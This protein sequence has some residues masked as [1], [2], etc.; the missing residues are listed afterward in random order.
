MQH[1]HNFIDG[2][3]ASSRSGQTLDVFEPATGH[4]YARVADSTTED[5]NAA[6]D[7]AAR[8]F[9]AWNALGPSGRSQ[10]LL[11]L[12]DLIDK[13]LE[14]LA[15]AESIDTGKPLSL[16]RS[17]DIPRSAAN[18]RFFAT[19]VLHAGGAGEFHEFDGGG[20]PAAQGGGGS[21]HALNYTLRAPRGSGVAGLISPWNLPL[22]LLT[23]KIAPALATG[24][25]AVC[26]PS[27]V[28]PMTATML[29]DLAVRAGIP[30]GVL[31]IVQGRG[32][33]VGG[34]IVQ[35]PN[36]P[37]ISFTGSTAVGRWIGREAGERL[38]RV[39]LELGGKNPFIVF[40]DV[41]PD[42]AVTAAVRGGYTNQGQVC[43]CGSRLLVHDRVY[44]KFVEM[45]VE[46]VRAFKVGDP[47]ESST[48]Q[49]ALVSREH[50][51]KVESRVELAKRLGARVLCGGSRV[52]AS[53]LPERCRGGCF[54]QPTVLE[55]LDPMCEVEQE[56]IFGPVVSLQRFKS[57]DEALA[58]AN[59]TKYGLAATLYTND[60]TRAHALAARVQAGIVW[61]NCW[62]V[63]DLRT[64]FGG[65]GQSGVGRE[66]GL[67]AIKFFTEAKNVCVRV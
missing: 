5:V 12:A 42:E 55:G 11:R 1:L 46:R 39:S 41:N 10:L 58:L 49:G 4:V 27:E 47:L 48:Q 53:A 56:E 57:D 30:A 32:G 29:G 66:G 20:M 50:L 23:W 38:K 15:R 25:T 9:P 64:P 6:V 17:I 61:V 65:M 19:A 36:V 44:A 35:H 45:F 34:T 8:A 40:D 33:S 67:E 3:S 62:L 54:Y 22:Y 28:T 63:R 59:S 51:E 21:L 18:L 31:N 43:L 2:V 60:L 24:N 14:E 37:T 7:A 26:K 13:N 52:S 16:A